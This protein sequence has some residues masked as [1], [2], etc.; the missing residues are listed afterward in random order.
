MWH[1]TGG[2]DGHRRETLPGSKGERGI[3]RSTK[4]GVDVGHM[5][6]LLSGLGLQ[7]DHF[8]QN[9]FFIFNTLHS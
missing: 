9:Y 8:T 1:H 7:R 4:E 2:R 6:S 5:E 3:L